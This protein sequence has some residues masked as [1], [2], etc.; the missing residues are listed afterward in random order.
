MNSKRCEDGRS[1]GAEC[2]VAEAPPS[3]LDPPAQGFTLIELL[4]V[5]AIIAILAA[6][7]LPALGNAKNRAQL[8]IDLN[9]NRQIMLAMTLYAGDN[10]D[11]MPWPC[12]NGPNIVYPGWA[13]DINLP[14]G[15][16]SNPNLFN[17]TLAAQIKS[18]QNGQLG[19]YLKAQKALMCPAD[20]VDSNF[21]LR[22]VYISSYVWNGAICGFGDLPGTTY[23]LT[24][25]KPDVILQWE[26]DE[27]TPGF[28]NDC[29]SNP[30]EGISLRHGKGASVGLVSGS[31]ERIVYSSWY[32]NNMAGAEGLRGSGIPSNLL[33]N[34]LW[35][36][37]G[38]AD[39][40]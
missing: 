6:L 13:Y 16:V 30:D 23:K 31:T 39:G 20:K 33:P 15:G 12:W 36:N 17:P 28:F 8:T 25:F 32:G 14:A 10:R 3:A 35:C 1:C 40:R 19:P 22:N 29:S 21:M 18:F 24:Q 26:T 2:P 37:P 38:Q 5:I 4:V 27:T 9:N 11:Y 7:L 34:R